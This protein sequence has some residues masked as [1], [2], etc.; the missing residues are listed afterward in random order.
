MKVRSQFP[1]KSKV[2]N[3]G[4]ILRKISYKISHVIIAVTDII[5]NCGIN[6]PKGTEIFEEISLNY[7]ER[8]LALN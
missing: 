6:F 8:Y 3:Y 1:S 2:G 4:R 5:E 7:S